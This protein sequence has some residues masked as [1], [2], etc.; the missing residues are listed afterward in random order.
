MNMSLLSST[1]T[2]IL[3]ARWWLVTQLLLTAILLALSIVWL[4]L[5]VQHTMQV[6]LNFALPL[7]IIATFVWLQ[8]ATM[9]SL[10]GDQRRVK[11]IFAAMT[12]VAWV[13]VAWV[14]LTLAFNFDDK[15]ELYAG[16]LNSRF[17]ASWR[18]Q[19]FTEEHI[20]TVFNWFEWVMIWVLIPGIFIPLA[21]L[22]SVTGAGLP[23]LRELKYLAQKRWWL[24][25]LIVAL[26][27]L[28]FFSTNFF[29]FALLAAVGLLPLAWSRIRSVWCNW[30]WWPVVF[31]AAF[32]VEH[33][34]PKLYDAEPHGSTRAQTWAVI[35]KTA[36]YYLVVVVSWLVLLIWSAVLLNRSNEKGS[37]DGAEDS[38][39][40][41]LAFAKASVDVQFLPYSLFPSPSLLR[42]C[43]LSIAWF[44]SLSASLLPPRSVWRIS[45]SSSLPTRFCASSHNGLSPG[46]LTL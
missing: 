36:A 35:L 18:A 27:I 31:V 39:V 6:V 24:P 8:S 7:L 12:F 28:W 37:D 2:R 43:P 13:L 33:L 41:V 29:Q 25:I 21:S 30:R 5:P 42:P 9:R 23:K 22:T 40:P 44:A 20:A 34:L 15:I 3:S 11:L 4:R 32:I 19:I 1:K 14:A 46:A 16:Y 38:L 17:P 26:V 10:M 45:K